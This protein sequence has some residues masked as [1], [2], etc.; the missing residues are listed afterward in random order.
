MCIRG[1]LNAKHGNTNSA[2]VGEVCVCEGLVWVWV[3]VGVGMSF[4]VGWLVG[5][6]ISMRIRA[7]GC[8]KVWYISTYLF[9]RELGGQR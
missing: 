9:F 2:G 8:D 5:W 4:L 3:F 6:F 1:L 7:E